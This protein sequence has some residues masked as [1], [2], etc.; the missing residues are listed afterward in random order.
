MNDNCKVRAITS[1][2]Q[3]IDEGGPVAQKIQ[4]ESKNRSKTAESYKKFQ[5][6]VEAFLAKSS[7]PMK[8]SL[9]SA[10]ATIRTIS[11]PSPLFNVSPDFNGQSEI[12]S[13]LIG[14]REGGKER[15]VLFALL[16]LLVQ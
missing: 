13:R 16:K 11:D 2:F 15:K 1:V 8:S 3:N 5:N 12:C 4:C 6:A 9:L 14:G 7:F 10:V